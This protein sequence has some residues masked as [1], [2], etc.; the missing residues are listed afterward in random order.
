MLNHLNFLQMHSNRGD[1]Q[2]FQWLLNTVCYTCIKTHL[3]NLALT[4]DLTVT[5]FDKCGT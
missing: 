3:D 1:L 4:S 5:L 2:I